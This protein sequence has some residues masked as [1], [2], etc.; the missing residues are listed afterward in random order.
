MAQ[1]VERLLPTPGNP[2]SNPAMK[3]F[4]EKLS[5]V[6]CI[7]SHKGISLAPVV[8]KIKSIEQEVGIVPLKQFQATLKRSQR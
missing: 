8:E 2:D 4:N 7:Q 3:F 1:L 6:N 5:T